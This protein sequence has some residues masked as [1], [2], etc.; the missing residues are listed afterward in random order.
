MEG[1]ADS[2]KDKK[3]GLCGMFEDWSLVWGQ[4]VMGNF[5]GR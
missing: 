5:L 1:V 2:S 3:E 4:G